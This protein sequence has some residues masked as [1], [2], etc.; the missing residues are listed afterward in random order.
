MNSNALVL[1]FA[2]AVVPVAGLSAQ[3]KHTDPCTLLKIAE[4]RIISPG[5]QIA[6][7][8]SS[9]ISAEAGAYGCLFKWGSGGNAPSG[10]YQLNVTVNDAS[11]TF[12]GTSPAL[13]KQGLLR[14]AKKG[15]DNTVA[16]PGVGEAAIF[17]S[18]APIRAAATAYL[19]GVVLEVN[20]EGPDGRA[21]KD[22]VIAL[23]KAAA[24]RL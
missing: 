21:K 8:V 14:A 6:P 17:Q 19:K 16:I 3:G 18:T 23:L 13:I 22:Q 5:A 9:T 20:L 2:M 4:I 12:P 1:G 24:G 11:K 7:G 15:E 10:L